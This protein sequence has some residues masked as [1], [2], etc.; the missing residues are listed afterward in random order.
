M[1]VTKNITLSC[2]ES[3]TSGYIQ[4]L[5][6]Q[7]DWASRFF[8]WGVCCYSLEQK[9]KI[10]WVDRDTAAACNCVS[11]LIAT[12]MAQGCQK[13]FGTTLSCATT[14]YASAYPEAWVTTPFAWITIV[15]QD[16][17]L[18]TEKITQEWLSRVEMQKFV[19]GKVIERLMK[20]I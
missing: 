7:H 2:A 3:L 20:V 17:V 15:S 16:K 8:A 18:Y 14:G 5:L 12:Q 4:T 9:V 19:A 1:C 11:E 13:L 10:L 6:G